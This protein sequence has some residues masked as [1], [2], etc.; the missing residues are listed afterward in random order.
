MVMQLFIWLILIAAASLLVTQGKRRK[1]WSVLLLGVLCVVSWFFIQGL[2]NETA[3]GFIYQWL[4]YKQLQADFNISASLQVRNMLLPLI[5][6]LA[7][8]VFLN[9]VSLREYCSLNVSVLNLLGFTALILLVSSHDFFQM[10]FASAMLSIICYYLPDIPL[11]RR[12]LFVY[13]FLSEIAAFVALAIVYNVVGSI[14]LSRLP[15]Y[16]IKGGHRDFVAFLLLFAMGCKSGLFMLNDQYN[17]LKEVSFNRLSG[18]LVLSVPFAGLIWLSKL[19]VLLHS[20]NY[21]GQFVEIWCGLTIMFSGWSV[22]INNNVNQKIISAAQMVYAL[23]FLSVYNH[24]ESLYTLVPVGL[25]IILLAS[26]MMY[27]LAGAAGYMKNQKINWLGII[28]AVAILF[29]IIG[30]GQNMGNAKLQKFAFTAYVAVLA[31]V[32]N[33]LV[34]TVNKKI[35]ESDSFNGQQNII[36]NVALG[37]S[38]AIVC[39]FLKDNLLSSSNYSISVPAVLLVLLP[40]G[41]LCRW[42]EM[43]IWQYRFAENVYDRLIVMPLKFFGR[44]LWLA[45]DFIFLEKGV[46]NTASDYSGRLTDYLRV[47]QSGTW[48]SLIFWIIIGVIALTIYAGV[49]GYD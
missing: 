25:A 6:L 45:V 42:G 19:G 35:I 30:L 3:S 4:P 14:S 28:I 16:V 20:T 21:A 7:V 15:D 49:L 1:V 9:V 39:F 37:T 24:A 40:M 23:M 10:L 34:V 17:N 8:I 41:W 26:S 12:K 31:M 36:Y 22:L 33:M 18:I 11:L 47:M 44:I 2:S 13:N 46:V 27:T 32:V 48:K 5:Y 43:P 29:T 38:A